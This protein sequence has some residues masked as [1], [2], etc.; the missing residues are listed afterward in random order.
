MNIRT[1]CFASLAAA[2]LLLIPS[3]V[4]ADTPD[5]GRRTRHNS[6]TQTPD[7]EEVVPEIAPKE[8]VTPKIEDI[9]ETK[10]E[11]VATETPA[12]VHPRTTRVDPIP[13]EVVPDQDVDDDSLVRGHGMQM[14]LTF[15]GIPGALLDR[16]FVKHGNTWD[17]SVNM[18][19]SLDYFLRFKQPCEMRFSL[20]WLN[21][22]T[23]DAYW[24]TRDQRNNPQLSDYIV[25]DYHIL[26][27]EVAAFHVVS[28]ID[29][30]AFYYGGGGWVG[31]T[32]GNA[33]QYAIRSSCALSSNNTSS[34]P[35]EPGSVEVLGIP[36]V[37][38]FVT[39]ALGFKFTILDMMTI[40]AEGG[41]KGYLYGQLGLGVEF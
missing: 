36:P 16:W 41:F 25:Q 22:K 31:L 18:G 24:L 19:F 3:V 30:V 35:H 29:E 38:G 32:M 2:S 7:F 33:K 39:V 26:S 37:F 8:E 5:G 11:P 40:R 15:A 20:S 1:S 21:A 28:I 34:C 17:D 4:L 10:P 23:G 14:G 13:V 12:A 6:R 9:P 27:L